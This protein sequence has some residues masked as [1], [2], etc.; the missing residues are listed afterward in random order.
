MTD[1][2]GAHPAGRGEREAGGGRQREE[3]NGQGGEGQEEKG[4]EARTALWL[5]EALAEDSPMD[6]ARHRP[7]IGLWLAQA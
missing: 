5:G 1:P 3:S 4:Y 2:A 7:R 6:S